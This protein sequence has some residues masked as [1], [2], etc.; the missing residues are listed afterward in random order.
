[1]ISKLFTGLCCSSPKLKGVLWKWWYQFLA[2]AYQRRDWGFMNYGYAPLDD[3]AGPLDLDEADADDRYCI[4][5]YH[6]VASGVDVNGLD[7]LE[8]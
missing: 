2:R 3:E 4:Q 7:V 6:H 1:M 8:D 5:L